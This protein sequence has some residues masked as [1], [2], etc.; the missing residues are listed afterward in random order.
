MNVSAASSRRSR[1]GR[2]CWSSARWAGAWRPQHGGAHG[3][4]LGPPADAA[5]RRPLRRRGLGDAAAPATGSR[6]RSTACPSF[7]CRRCSTGSPPP[8]WP[9]AAPANGRRALAAAYAMAAHGGLAKGLTGLVLPALVVL[10][11]PAV[12]FLILVTRRGGRAASRRAPGP[13][14][15][16]AALRLRPAHLRPSGQPGA[17]GGRL[18]RSRP[19]ATGQLAQ[20]STCW[21]CM[22]FMAGPHATRA[23]GSPGSTQ[24]P[25]PTC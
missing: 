2:S 13:S 12:V 7:T 8:P 4:G 14:V 3:H 9:C 23:C 22:A 15:P 5:R 19:P 10:A 17:G 1:P 6:P 25:T 20:T 11:G 24:P 18:V 21:A 16:A